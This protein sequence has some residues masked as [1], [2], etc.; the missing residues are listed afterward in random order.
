MEPR[1][2]SLCS[3]GGERAKDTRMADD[4]A[5]ISRSAEEQ[6]L[7]DHYCEYPGC[8]KWGGLG[9]DVDQGTQWF[10]S[11]HKWDDYR[12]GKARRSFFDDEALGI[13]AIMIEPPAVVGMG[14]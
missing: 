11:E 4:T 9:Y 14:R 5:R 10:C 8:V 12:L 6:M 7:E 1:L 2:R 13:D 3:D